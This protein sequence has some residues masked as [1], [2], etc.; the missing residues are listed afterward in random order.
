MSYS[1]K[2]ILFF[3]FGILS[4]IIVLGLLQPRLDIDL[5]KDSPMTLKFTSTNINHF[6]QID[7]FS[8]TKKEVIWRLNTKNELLKELS[9]GK[10][11]LHCVQLIPKDKSPPREMKNGEEIYVKIDYQYD[12]LFPLGAAANSR[13]AFFIWEDGKAREKNKKPN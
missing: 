13:T 9:F 10:V 4:I 3:V 1:I 12:S 7:V 2:V 5:E 6:L 8:V 11:P